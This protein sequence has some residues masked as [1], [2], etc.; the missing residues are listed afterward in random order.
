MT[1]KIPLAP[2][3]D[4]ISKL[5][6]LA[7]M[8]DRGTPH[9]AALAG[10]KMQAMLQQYNLTRSDIEG[11]SPNESPQSKRERQE[12]TKIT[13]LYR[14]Q[15]DLMETI[16]ENNFCLHFIA[17]R[18]VRDPRGNATKW[19]ET[20]QD[21]VAARKVKRHVLIGRADNV[22]ATAL[23]YDYL[24]T[25][26]DNLSPY[27]GIDRRGSEAHLWL[28]GCVETLCSRLRQQRTGVEEQEQ[29]QTPGLMRL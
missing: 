18:F 25:A 15:R 7:T 8:H 12:Q 4:I 16:A 27:K 23:M 24:T 14:W 3:P 13:A 26:M 11:D 29:I 20:E 6:K 5:K 28:A 22:A 21:Y 19:S 1:N 10:E 17:T 9:E 2:P